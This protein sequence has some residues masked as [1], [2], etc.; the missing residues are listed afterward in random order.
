MAPVYVKIRAL[1][2]VRLLAVDQ[3]PGVRPLGCGEIWTRL[4]SGTILDQC[5]KERARDARNKFY[6]VLDFSLAWK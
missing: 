4:I 3:E 5:T 2:D 6:Y 1:N